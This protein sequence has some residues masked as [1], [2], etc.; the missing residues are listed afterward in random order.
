MADQPIPR[1]INFRQTV[2][3][4]AARDPAFPVGLCRESLQALLDRDFGTAK[5]LVGDFI[6]TNAG[7]RQ[8]ADER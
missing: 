5:I 3:A 7:P 1:T 8:K 6:D 4:P 2:K